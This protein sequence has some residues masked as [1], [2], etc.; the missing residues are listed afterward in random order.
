MILPTPLNFTVSLKDSFE[1]PVLP[2][3]RPDNS[4]KTDDPVKFKAYIERL[5]QATGI[6]ITNFD[7]LIEA[8]DNRHNFFHVHGRPFIRSW[9][10]QV[11]FCAVY[12]R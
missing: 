2:T 1:I 6:E 11:L 10:G 5:E 4:I 8:L 7:S 12:R 9:N 3:F